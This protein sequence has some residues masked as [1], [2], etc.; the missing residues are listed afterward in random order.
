MQSSPHWRVQPRSPSPSL[1]G[2]SAQGSDFAPNESQAVGSLGCQN[3]KEEYSPP[4]LQ[5]LQRMTDRMLRFLVCV[6]YKIN[7]PLNLPFKS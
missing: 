3:S 6:H 2:T 5:H 7:L 1:S 4:P